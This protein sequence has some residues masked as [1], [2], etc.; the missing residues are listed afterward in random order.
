MTNRVRC[1]SWL[2][3]LCLLALSFPAHAESEIE[4]LRKEVR[5]LRKTVNQ[6]SEVVRE[7]NR[8][9]ETITG[10]SG[11]ALP[12]TETQTASETATPT[13]KEETQAAKPTTPSGGDT[14][15]AELLNQVNSAPAPAGSTSRSVGLWRYPSGGS[16]AAKLLP[17]ISF[18]PSFGVGYFSLDPTGDTGH[19]P[20][21]TGFTLQEIE[22]AV[23]SVIDPY[24]RGDIFLS[25][26]EDGVELEEGYFTTLGAGLPR[27]LQFRGGKFFIP[28]GRQN[29]KHLHNWAFADQNL[30][31][32]QLF[33]PEGLAELGLELSYLFPTPFFLQLQGTF[34]NGDNDTSFGGTRKQD[35]LYNGRLSASVDLTP[36]LTALV[37]ASGAFG[38]NNSGPGETTSLYGGDFLLKWKPSARTSVAWQTEYILRRMGLP[39]STATDGGLYSYV[40]VQFLK[41]WHAAFRYD[42]MGIP[43]GIVPREFRLTPAISFDPTEFSRIRLQYEFD[44][45][46]NA[47]PVHSMFLQF[48]FSLG[49]HGAHP[50]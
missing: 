10:K 15:V 35:F 19:D 5:E 8:R 11:P 47:D 13:P 1:S 12:A 44:K 43:L 29:P 7:Q 38:F 6:L 25:F 36:D 37:G 17:D 39:G 4:L 18:I 21:R 40:D 48:Q 9:I 2:L 41:Q 3:S 22:M 31:N 27:G 49:P 14:E 34:S 42:Q 50:F 16:G 20:A 23:S 32:K 26:H 46:A 30:V 24:F 33:G 45:I 28:F